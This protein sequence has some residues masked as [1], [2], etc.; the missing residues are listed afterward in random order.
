MHVLYLTNDA[1]SAGPFLTHSLAQVR[2][3][4]RRNRQQHCTCDFHTTEPAA[5]HI[6]EWRTIY[7]YMPHNIQVL[8]IYGLYGMQDRICHVHHNM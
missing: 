1:A 6:K 5:D 4:K 7:Q 8:V 3:C 2:A